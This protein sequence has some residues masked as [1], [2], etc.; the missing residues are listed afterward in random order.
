MLDRTISIAPMMDCT[1]RHYRY[2]ARLLS[3][4]VLL[5]SEMVHCNAIIHGDRERH[6]RFNGEEHPVALQL[7]GANPQDL[8]QAA[9]IAEDYG[10]DEVNLNVGCPSSRV[11]AGRFG[12]CLMAEP[13]LVA[14]CIVAMREVVSIPVTVKT[15]LGIDYQDSDKLLHQF[16]ASVAAAGCEVFIVHARKAWLTGLSPKQNRDV[17]PLQYERVYRLREVFPQLTIV[18]NGGIKT[19][20]AIGDHLA[21]VDGVM[22][23]REAYHN[24]YWL[25]ALEQRFYPN[26]DAVPGR[27]AI[28]AEY[29]DYIAAQYAQGVPL[30]LMTRHLI[31]LYQGMPG[32][33]QWRRFLCNN[34]LKSDAQLF[35]FLRAKHKIAAILSTKGQVSEQLAT[36]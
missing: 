13:A 10:Y 8:A 23:G 17:P 15:R 35:D 36:Q 32:A 12:A 11:Q 9:K 18:I 27:A 4:H 24:L 7:G 30:N 21:H 26:N 2:L 29:S 20:Q 5:Y 19:A 14:A 25:A 34:A 28:L 22:I 6:L 1:D 16:I 3:K 33:K 31:G